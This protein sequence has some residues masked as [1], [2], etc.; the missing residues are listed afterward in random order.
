MKNDGR[1]LSHEILES[2]RFAAIS[3]YKRK[4]AVSK[5]AD[6]FQVTVQAVYK[7]LHTVKQYGKLAL[8]SRKAIGRIPQLTQEQF[9]KLKL[10]LK[11]PATKLGYETD[12]WSGPRVRHLIKNK[13][14]VIYHQ[15]HMPRFL[16]RLGL[17]LKFP[18]RRAL[19]QDPHEVRQWKEKRLPEILKYAQ[20]KHALVFYADEALISLIPY[21]GKTWTFPKV[22]P[23]VFVSGKR[24]QHIGITA[25]VNA[26]GRMSFEMT[27]EG[28]KF[29]AKTFIRFIK[30]LKYGY[31]RRSIIL[32]IDGAPSHTAKAVTEFAKENE[33][34]LRIEIIP[35]YSPELNPTEKQWRY[36]KTKKLNAS[37][38]SNKKDLKRTALK[39]MKK[40]KNDKKR[41]VNFFI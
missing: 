6:S 31:Q 4:V 1:S 38:V 2:Y 18:E 20:K 7:W 8:K 32:I 34:W 27:K 37:T 21:V 17:C 25:A 30:K 29:T 3:L 5:I 13:F 16:R 12:L 41:I 35:A 28:E 11:R 39:V 9:Y 40:L 26:Q 10:L 23:I 36:I 19:E 24:G 14:G 33:S 15:K 22:K